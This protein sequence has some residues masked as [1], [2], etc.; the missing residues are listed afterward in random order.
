VF[1]EQL[2]HRSIVSKFI[3]SLLLIVA[4]KNNWREFPDTR[5][6]TALFDTRM[7]AQHELF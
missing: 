5:T 1:L 6:A 7:K 2:I 4:L 3:W